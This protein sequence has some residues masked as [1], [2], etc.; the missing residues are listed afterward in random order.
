[1]STIHQRAEMIF[2]F[3]NAR[4]GERFT[5]GQLCA[6]LGL[7]NSRKT[8]QAIGTARD[9]ADAAGVHLPPACPANGFTYTVTTEP[10]PAVDPM[11]HI[12]RVEAGERRRARTAEQFI[13]NRLAM[14][15]DELRPQVKARLKMQDTIDAAVDSLQAVLAE[16]DAE[17]IS[18]RR[19]QR[20]HQES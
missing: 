12:R 10:E 1:M 3:L 18:Q 8:H 4:L 15:P 16:F 19:D 2:G 11:L 5:I 20:H 9:L 14:L 7:E 13:R 17:L 6:A